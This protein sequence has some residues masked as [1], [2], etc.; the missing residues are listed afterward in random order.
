MPCD[1]PLIAAFGGGPINHTLGF[2]I[3]H[4]AD[5]EKAENICRPQG[6]LW[7]ILAASLS[8]NK[9]WLQTEMIL[10]MFI[11]LIEIF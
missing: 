10:P 7:A 11:L 2:H 8:I 5:L 1:P 9:I 6:A 4:S 3:T